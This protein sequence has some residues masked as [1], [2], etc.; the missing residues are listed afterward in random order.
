MHSNDDFFRSPT[1]PVRPKNPWYKKW[2]GILF[3]L[4]FSLFAVIG[5]ATGIYVARIAWLINTGVITPED[6]RAGRPAGSVAQEEQLPTNVS[7]DDPSI[8]S[9]DAPVVIVEF[10]DFQC[11][12]CKQ[13]VPVI[14]Q[15]LRDYGDQVYLQY[16][17]FPNPDAHPQAINSAIAAE[18]AHEQGLFWPMHDI[19]FENQESI[20][21]ENLKRWA[22]QVGV[23]NL[24]FSRCF[25][26]QRYFAEV[27]QDFQDAVNAGASATPTF[28]VNG[29]KIEG[30][31][32]YRTFEQIIISELR[33]N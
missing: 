16:R 18:C 4:A 22:V 5:V 8:G 19:I 32:S 21:V 2:W 13:T 33:G 11:P 17:D 12:F 30:A 29:Q 27:E 20:S 3:I 24:Q 9:A 31:V 26:D 7:S 10:S 6:L 23:N 15:I 14:K 1:Q 25:D 28:F